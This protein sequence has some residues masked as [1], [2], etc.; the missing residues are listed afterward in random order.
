ML[1]QVGD[2]VF[3]SDDDAFSLG[4]DIFDIRNDLHNLHEQLIV[5]LE[6]FIGGVFGY[7]L[8]RLLDKVLEVLQSCFE[9]VQQEFCVHLVP[10]VHL[11]V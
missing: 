8:I 9:L 4:F 5:V 3:E 6:V 11:F 10:L 1:F 7:S 2:H